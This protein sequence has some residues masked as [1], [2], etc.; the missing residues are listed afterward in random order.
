MS[1]NFPKR[2]WL[3]TADMG[4]GHQRAAL[5]LL[6]HAEGGRLLA[7]NDYPGIPDSDRR[8]WQEISGFYNFISRF[9][10]RGWLGRKIFAFYDRFQR[11]EDFYPRR[12]RS[13]STW[14]LRQIASRIRKG[15]GRHLVEQLLSN[16]L[17]ILTTYFIAG[18]MAE[19]WNY[20]G[21]IFTVVTD[22]DIPRAWVPPVPSDSKITYLASTP[23]SAERLLQYGVAP[24]RIV[25][26]GFPLPEELVRR[27]PELLP[28]RLARLDPRGVFR[29][30]WAGSLRQHLGQTRPVKPGPVAITFAIG[31]AGAQTELAKDLFGLTDL[32]RT[33]RIRL[34][35]MAGISARA[36][37]K[38]QK[39]ARRLGLEKYLGTGLKICLAE[40]KD[41]NYRLMNGILAET[42]ILW[43]KPSELCFYAGLG[44]P[45]IMAEPVGSHEERNREWLIDLGAGKDQ[46][47]P[48]C[49]GEW[50]WDW[51]LSGKLAEAAFQGYL[52]IERHGAENIGKALARPP[53]APR[54]V[55]DRQTRLEIP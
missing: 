46:L 23:R 30:R 5:P 37:G 25:V 21:P 16:P 38:F 10:G 31:G 45:V 41:E 14:Q 44:L 12:D 2:A 9:K 52:K 50:L 51:I 7:A 54:T 39:V 28:A 47:D 22:S 4:Y 36:A 17:P 3:I 40:T 20:P 6:K 42:D 8:V 55:E 43:T 27:T 15:W 19:H 34:N 49:A 26:T 29:K 32:I 35:L 53:L 11:V 18:H 24:E 13:A 1:R 33:G 48:N